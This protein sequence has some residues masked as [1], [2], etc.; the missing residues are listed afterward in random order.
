MKDYTGQQNLTFFF[1][2]TRG[3]ISN[4]NR[5][6]NTEF[7][8][9]SSFSPS[10]TVFSDSQVKCERNVYIYILHTLFTLTKM[11]G[12]LISFCA[13]HL[14]HTSLSFNSSHKAFLHPSVPGIAI[15]RQ[16]CLGGNVPCVR[17]WR[18]QDCQG[19]NPGGNPKMYLEGHITPHILVWL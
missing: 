7:K 2:G 4:P 19:R 18:H 14:E 8:Y 12:L 1:F 13:W 5:T 11:W 3:K 15:P 16:K 9:V 17:H 6:F 10:P